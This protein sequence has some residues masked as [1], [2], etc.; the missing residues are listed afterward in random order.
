MG[1]KEREQ[2]GRDGGRREGEG[3]EG[4]REGGKEGGL[5]KGRDREGRKK[6]AGLQPHQ[7]E[8]EDSSAMPTS[9]P[10]S[11]ILSIQLEKTAPSLNML[12]RASLSKGLIV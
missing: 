7:V 10:Y 2:G 8:V 11:C 6:L 4:R 12:L 1:G 3:M 9:M 5:E